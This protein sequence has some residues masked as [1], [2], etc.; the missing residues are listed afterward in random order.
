MSTMAR[1]FAME[2]CDPQL[3]GGWVLRLKSYSSLQ[4]LKSILIKLC[5][6][7]PAPEA[8]AQTAQAGRKFE[9][10]LPDSLL[11]HRDAIEEK[12]VTDVMRII[13][14]LLDQLV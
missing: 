10:F 9:E 5:E 13:H 8:L 2:E 4:R 6:N 14:K 1:M 7:P 3:D 12:D 11:K